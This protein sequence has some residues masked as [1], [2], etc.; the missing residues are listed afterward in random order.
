MR[1]EV[2]RGRATVVELSARDRRVDAGAA[3]ALFSILYGSEFAEQAD[4]S[5]P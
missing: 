1:V 3:G 4:S 2:E 5:D